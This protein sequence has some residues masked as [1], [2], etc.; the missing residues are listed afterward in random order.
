MDSI[1]PKHLV[2][3]ELHWVRISSFS[4]NYQVQS[5]GIV[6]GHSVGIL[7]QEHSQMYRWCD[8]AGS[9]SQACCMTFMLPTRT[10]EYLVAITGHRLSLSELRLGWQ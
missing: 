7:D 10:Y 3:H 1:I 9:Y 4:K 5:K 8:S 6:T 2:T